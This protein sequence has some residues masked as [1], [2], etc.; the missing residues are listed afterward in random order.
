MERRPPG[1]DDGAMIGTTERDRVEAVILRHHG[2]AR[3]L[4][5]RYARPG[6]AQFE[7]LEQVALVGLV[8]AAQRFDPERGTAFSSYA[9]PTI[10]G[11]LRRFF[12]ATSWTAHVPRPR[13]ETTLRLQQ[14]D[15]EF[16]AAHGRSPSMAEAAEALGLCIEEVLETRLAERS[17]APVS[18]DDGGVSTDD[19]D[20]SRPLVERLGQDDPGYT[21]VDLRDA[22][23]QAMA[24]LETRTQE[25][26]R[27]RVQE[28]LTFAE[29]GARMG[30]SSTQA[31]KL[32]ERASRELRVL[33]APSI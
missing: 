10:L 27:L 9:V 30:I 33:L 28:E 21:R 19:D 1:R 26:F 20:T 5:G 18:L 25:A 2:L 12:R 6:T 17:R 15:E 24:Q 8:K 23:E 14:L 7:D 32:C 22:L 31:S 4:A 13:Q 16:R 29:L 3:R 11:E